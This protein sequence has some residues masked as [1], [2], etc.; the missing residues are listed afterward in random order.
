MTSEMTIAEAFRSQMKPHGV[1]VYGPN[2]PKAYA[3][4]RTYRYHRQLGICSAALSLCRAR[5]MVEE[6]KVRYPTYGYSKLSAPFVNGGGRYS[7][8]L[9]WAENPGSV[10]LRVVW[11]AED[12]YQ[13]D[14][15][16]EFNAVVYLL[17]GRKGQ[18]Q[19]VAGYLDP[20]NDGPAAICFEEVF[21]T[22]ITDDR[23]FSGSS[24]GD[25]RDSE[26]F[27]DAKHSAK[28]IARIACE[29]QIEDNI[30]FG[31][32]QEAETL[33]QTIRDLRQERRTLIA[34]LRTTGG[35]PPAICSTIRKRVYSIRRES[36]EAHKRLAAIESGL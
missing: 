21:R 24:D 6:G 7:D 16:E 3:I 18:S 13:D 10:G 17:P 9:R 4:A 11:R 34:E 30:R 28:E 22:D 33:T 29:S 2:E 32:E 27:R 31:R 35:L 36:R 15:G 23:G 25:Y 5:T 19:L 20:C 12:G 26:A 14:N 1:G 8:K